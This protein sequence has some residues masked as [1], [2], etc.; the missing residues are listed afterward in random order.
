MAKTRNTKRAD[1]RLQARIYLGVIDGKAKYKYVYGATQK[2]LN[3]KLDEVKLQLGKGLDISAQ[4]DTFGEWAQRWLKLKKTEVSNHRYYIYECRIKNLS[5]LEYMEIPKI[6]SMDIQDIIIDYS[7]DYSKSVL[8]EIKS[9]AHQILQLAVDNRVI[10]YN[11]ASAVKIPNKQQEDKTERRALSDEEQ[12]WILDTPHRS[13]TA[14]MIMMYAGLRRGEVVPLLWTDVDLKEGTISV[15]KSMSRSGSKWI[16]KHGAKTE[17]G[18][19]TVYIP[20]ILT[21]YLKSIDRGNSLMVCPNSKGKTM[22]LSAWDKMWDSYISEL[23]FKYGDFSQVVVPDKDGKLQPFKKPKSRFA[24]VKIPIVIP[25][26]TPHWLRHTFITSM[27]L[28]GVDVL[29]AK[30]QA[31]HA[32]INTTMAIYTHLDAM[33]KVKQID[34]LNSYYECQMGVSDNWKQRNIG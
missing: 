8:K 30:E 10:D 2:E 3:A 13:Q 1:G 31:G 34:K 27:Y 6:R 17:A 16:A 14:A 26:I 28:A 24:P 19:R 15:T 32:D 18:V 21:E 20:Q 5:A 11:P 22:S 25:K 29:T 9:T 12:Q 7:E 33:H 23:N 4:R